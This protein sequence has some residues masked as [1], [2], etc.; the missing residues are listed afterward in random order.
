MAPKKKISSKLPSSSQGRREKKEQLTRNPPI[1]YTNSEIEER[2][3]KFAKRKIRPSRYMSKVGL[4]SLGYFDLVQS[5]LTQIGMFHFAFTPFI[6][7]PQL[8]I[9]FLSSFCLRTSN[10]IFKLGGKSYFLTKE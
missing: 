9:T 10:S 4:D 3:S 8:V 6:T 7:I 5:L 2:A 1:S